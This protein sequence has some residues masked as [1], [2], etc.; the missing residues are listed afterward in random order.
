MSTPFLD[1]LRLTNKTLTDTLDRLSCREPSPTAVQLQSLSDSIEQVGQ[2]WTHN[3]SRPNGDQ[4]LEAEIARY[5]E[6]LR[7]LK[8]AL[9]GL[10]PELDRRRAELRAEL[11]NLRAALRWAATLKQTR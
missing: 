9:E 3:T 5:A 7:R 6:N 11:T 1:L 4:A 2:A 10:R 8:G